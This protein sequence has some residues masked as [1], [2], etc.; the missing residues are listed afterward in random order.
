MRIML[1]SPEPS[2]YIKLI[3]A[4]ADSDWDIFRYDQPFKALDNLGEISPDLVV[5]N[6]TSFPRHWKV[7]VS[8]YAVLFDTELQLIL[9]S[10]DEEIAQEEGEKADALG[11]IGIIRN[12]LT[13]RKVED[14]IGTGDP[15]EPQEHDNSLLTMTHPRNFSI[16]HGK[17][18][19]FRTDSIVFGA[20]KRISEFPVGTVF[21]GSHIRV[22]DTRITLDLILQQHSDNTCILAIQSGQEEYRALFETL[23]STVLL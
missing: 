4:G 15:S 20:Q 16:I 12:G 1:I 8:F 11:V 5:W 3:T 9:F 23:R 17:I 7:L 22:H 21:A 19:E 6:V 14:I 10:E 13:S 2:D 18:R